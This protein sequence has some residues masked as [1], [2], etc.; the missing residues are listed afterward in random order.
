M[1][2]A[3]LSP[4]CSPLLS[5]NYVISTSGKTIGHSIPLLEIAKRNR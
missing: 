1:L 3:D 2:D 4:V 5:S